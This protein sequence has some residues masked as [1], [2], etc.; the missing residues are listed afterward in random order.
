MAEHSKLGNFLYLLSE[1]EGAPELDGI[2]WTAPIA[3]AVR[4]RLIAVTSEVAIVAERLEGA[5]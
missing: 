4:E 3:V 5:R 2:E 1:M